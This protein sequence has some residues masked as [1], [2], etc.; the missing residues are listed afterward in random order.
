MSSLLQ[1]D[2]MRLIKVGP[3]LK[4]RIERRIASAHHRVMVDRLQRFREQLER[5]MVP[6]PWTDLET[7]AVAILYD[8]CHALELNE[9]ERL[10]VLGQEG[11]Q[12]LDDLLE[13]RPVPLLNERQSKAMA[14]LQDYG[15]ISL[16]EYRQICPHWSDETLRLDL[17]SLVARG[18]LVKNGRKKGTSYTLAE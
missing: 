6:R 15:R 1:I 14:Y 4:E 8:V 3:S 9:E 16:S 7:T 18:L 12:A 11:D 5:E 17:A 10:M 13:N 2:K